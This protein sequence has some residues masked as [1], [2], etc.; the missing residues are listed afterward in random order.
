MTSLGGNEKKRRVEGPSSSSAATATDLD[1]ARQK[2]I[3]EVVR[4]VPGLLRLPRDLIEDKVLPMV[5]L[6]ETVGTLTRVLL[7]FTGPGGGSAPRNTFLIS[8]ERI[9]IRK[10]TMT[11]R[12]LAKW[13]PSS[14]TGAVHVQQLEEGRALK[15]KMVRAMKLFGTRV[16]HLVV[17]RQWEV[18]SDLHEHKLFPK[19][20]RLTC[21]FMERND[22]Q[23]TVARMLATFPK[24]VDLELSALE[25][26]SLEPDDFR[27]DTHRASRRWK[28]VVMPLMW[29]PVN[30]DVFEFTPDVLLELFANKQLKTLVWDLLNPMFFVESTSDLGAGWTLEHLETLAERADGEM[31]K[32]WTTPQGLSAGV[33]ATQAL[34][35]MLTHFPRLKQFAM[36]S[37]PWRVQQEVFAD[38]VDQWGPDALFVTY[39]TKEGMALVPLNVY[40]DDPQWAFSATDEPIVRRRVQWKKTTLRWLLTTRFGP[41]YPSYPTHWRWPD[42]LVESLSANDW[43]E[44]GELAARENYFGFDDLVVLV[45]LSVAEAI[46]Q[47]PTW[48]K[49]T[50]ELHRFPDVA[51]LRITND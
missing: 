37:R 31:L 10:L 42:L 11:E 14:R 28:R 4:A 15:E 25:F 1:G 18:F 19:L 43:R 33:D 6:Y 51:R 36:G 2:L 13:F 41:S 16:E 32:V 21:K 46:A 29:S 48:S 30:S 40:S 20:E 24:L 5:G 12:Q 22:T 35:F 50:V 49:V 3:D 45:P 7:K 8:P 17:E 39:I 38:A 34:R 47:Q 9:P 44:L 27:N 26:V 23:G